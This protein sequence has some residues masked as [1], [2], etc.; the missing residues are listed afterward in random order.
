MRQDL[1]F[2]KISPAEK[3]YRNKKMY[4]AFNDYNAFL[5][6]FKHKLDTI[7]SLLLNNI[8]T[9][10]DLIKL[11]RTQWSLFTKDYQSWMG[12]I[13]YQTN[14]PYKFSKL[15]PLGQ[16]VMKA[17]ISRVQRNRS[18]HFAEIQKLDIWDVKNLF[19]NEYKNI[20]N[21]EN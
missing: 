4:R 5:K 14:T 17:S 21:R 13:T 15:T 19:R 8:Y 11:S 1:G 10:Q 6:N 2:N 3:F 12:N 7:Q 16:E 18:Y 9:C 20:I